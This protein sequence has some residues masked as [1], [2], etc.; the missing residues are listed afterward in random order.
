MRLPPGHESL[1]TAD[2]LRHG[3]LRNTWLVRPPGQPQTGSFPKIPPGTSSG[4]P[5]TGFFQNRQPVRVDQENIQPHPPGWHLSAEERGPQTAP[6][7]GSVEMSLTGDRKPWPPVQKLIQRGVLF[8][9]TGL[10]F[11]N[12][13]WAFEKTSRPQRTFYTTLWKTT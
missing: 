6:L 3:R 7:N 9:D 2:A 1:C 12:T 5:P 11:C 8:L 13:F 10:I 4:Q